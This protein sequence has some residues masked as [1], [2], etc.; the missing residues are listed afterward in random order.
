MSAGRVVA[1][2]GLLVAL[3]GCGGPKQEFLG[4]RVEDTCDQQW[5]ICATIAGCMLGDRS[6]QEGRFPNSG[7]F[8]VQ[9]FE[10]SEVKL[11]FF[12]EELAGTGTETVLNFYEDRCRNRVQLTITGKELI[13][14]HEKVGY[15]FRRADLTGIGDHLIEYTSD[16]RTKYIAKVDVTPLRIRDQQSE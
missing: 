1:Y 2:A 5:P 15:I 8:I 13:A 4:Q 12:L 10:P 7:R 11:S 14:E 6:Y 3:L 16:A 9:L